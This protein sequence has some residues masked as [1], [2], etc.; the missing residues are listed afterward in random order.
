MLLSR[1]KKS[2]KTDPVQLVAVAAGAV[3]IMNS[4][5]NLCYLSLC[6]N[7]TA[8]QFILIYRAQM[9]VV[10]AEKVSRSYPFGTQNNKFETTLE[11]EIPSMMYEKIC[12][13]N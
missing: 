1:T 3:W 9:K 11:L 13:N 4:H 6:V 12:S 7:I 10:D 5:N 2:S 8:E